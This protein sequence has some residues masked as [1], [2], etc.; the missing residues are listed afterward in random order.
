M[1]CSHDKGRWPLVRRLRW[2]RVLQ[3]VLNA[4]IIAISAYLI[5]FLNAN[6]GN[7]GGAATVPVI[8]VGVCPFLGTPCFLLTSHQAPLTFILTVLQQW[9]GTHLS[10]YRKRWC[11]IFFIFFDLTCIGLQVPLIAVLAVAGLPANCDGVANG[12]D[13]SICTFAKAF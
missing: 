13:S 11:L 7:L 4:V 6:G 12:L 5:S 9:F 1:A 10:G 8:V 3:Y 2:L